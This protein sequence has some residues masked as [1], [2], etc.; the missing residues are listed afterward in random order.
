MTARGCVAGLK[1]CLFLAGLFHI[2]FDHH[3]N[4]LIKAH[5]GFPSQYVFSLGRIPEEDVDLG[6]TEIL[7]IDD[8]VFLIIEIQ[9]PENFLHKFLYGM[10]FAGGDDQIIWLFLLEHEPH[11]LHIIPRK[12]PIPFCIEVAEIQF[13]LKAEFNPGRRAGYLAGNKGFPPARGFM[14][15]QD[16]VAGKELIGIPVV[17]DDVVGIDLGSGIGT[18][19]LEGRQL[20]LGRGAA[21][22]ISLDEA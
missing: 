10:S 1:E 6:G 21:P 19:R 11:G 2:R 9:L 5:P 14:V 13:I 12:P 3:V 22:N 8:D 20:V 17:P 18:L 15:K 7:G 16:A 4:Q